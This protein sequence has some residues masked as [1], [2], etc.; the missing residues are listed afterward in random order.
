MFAKIAK[1]A[2]A[3]GVIGM[4][5]KLV[6]HVQKMR[7]IAGF[8]GGDGCIHVSDR[9]VRVTYVQAKKGI[10]NIKYIQDIEG[11]TITK[12]KRDSRSPNRQDAYA[13]TLCGTDALDHLDRLEPHIISKKLQCE[14]AL[15]FPRVDLRTVA[16]AHRPDIVAERISIK[17]ECSRLKHIDEDIDPQRMSL[18]VIGGWMAAEGCVQINAQGYAS[19]SITQKQP[20]VLIAIR[21]F[22]ECGN[23][24][25]FKWSVSKRDDVEIIARKLMGLSGAKDTA[26]AILIEYLAMNSHHEIHGLGSMFPR[27]IDS[28]RR[29][30]SD[31]NGGSI[32]IR[33]IDIRPPT[34]KRVM[35][36]VVNSEITGYSYKDINGIERRFSVTRHRTLDDAKG[37]A[38]GAQEA[39]MR[40]KARRRR[41][42]IEAA[43]SNENNLA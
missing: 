31:L 26:L 21:D 14:S 40:A 19:L 24:S 6:T 9:G 17:D 3:T 43:L 34:P 22:F 7:W 13:L 38:L 23:V 28:R 33:D 8:L 39:V 4:F 15:N 41:N 29:A 32:Q 20:N 37:L 36:I 42:T 10:A 5:S 30:I 2:A 35:P 27:D 11:G 12:L 18:E 1:I 16:I 25:G